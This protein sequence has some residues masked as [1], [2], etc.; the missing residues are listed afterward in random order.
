MLYQKALLQ[1]IALQNFTK[2]N[3]PY[4]GPAV[5]VSVT[6]VTWASIALWSIHL[7]IKE[8]YVVQKMYLKAKFSHFVDEK[9]KSVN[10]LFQ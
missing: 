10:C 8:F 1:D 5:K 2:Y 3:L 6:I 7:V 9:R 4:T